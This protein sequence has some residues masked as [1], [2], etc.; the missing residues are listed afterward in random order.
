MFVAVLDVLFPSSSPSSLPFFF[1]FSFSSPLLPFF[2]STSPSASLST[3]HVLHPIVSISRVYLSP[4]RIFSPPEGER[5]ETPTWDH[6]AAEFNLKMAKQNVDHLKEVSR[7]R[8]V[9]NKIQHKERAESR[10]QTK[11]QVKNKKKDSESPREPGDWRLGASGS[12]EGKPRTRLL[13]IGTV[14]PFQCIGDQQVSG[15][16]PSRVSLVSDPMADLYV[17]TSKRLPRMLQLG[18]ASRLR[19]VFCLLAT[20]FA[21]RTPSTP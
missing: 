15:T 13:R 8:V 10:R 11:E 21:L 16:E 2:V 7:A 5:R 3:L 12:V 14:G 1:A 9:C 19:V 18:L 6:G 17:M 20:L 4:C